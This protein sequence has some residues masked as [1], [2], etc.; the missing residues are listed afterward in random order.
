MS[1]RMLDPDFENS[2][3]LANLDKKSPDFWDRY[4]RLQ[5]AIAHVDITETRFRIDFTNQSTGE[6]ITLDNIRL[7]TSEDQLSH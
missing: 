1:D 5:E 3:L 6:T 7:R 2:P 4:F